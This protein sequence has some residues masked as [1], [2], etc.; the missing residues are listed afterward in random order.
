MSAI[1]QGELIELT[2]QDLQQLNQELDQSDDYQTLDVVTENW[3]EELEARWESDYEPRPLSKEEEEAWLEYEQ[4]RL[5]SDLLE[6]E[7]YFYNPG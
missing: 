7:E 1:Y 2:P 4:L 5:E 3:L 6:Q